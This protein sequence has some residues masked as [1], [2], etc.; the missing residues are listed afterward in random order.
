[1]KQSVKHVFF[2]AMAGI[3]LLAACAPAPAPTQDPAEVQ[4]QIQESVA[5]TVA[6]QNAEAEQNQAVV[7]EPTN[8]PLPTQT[9][10]VPASP[11]PVEPTATPFTVVPPTV[12]PVSSGSGGGGAVTPLEYD[13]NV[14]NRQ[15]LDNTHFK[16]NKE[17]DIRW[18]IINTGTKSWPAGLD[19]K[20]YSGP[21]M[22]TTTVAEL[23]AMAPGDTFE[24]I[25]DARAPQKRGFQVMT[26]I[27]EGKLCYPYV[28][29]IVGE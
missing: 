10:A 29:I 16:P 2:L 27:V 12:T 7:A 28:A 13:C 3:L 5:L 9:E 22:S 15:P 25:L 20:Y 17:F 26:W 19:V 14:G 21:L 8:T 18:T 11:T 1:M 6:A 24:V 4:R 23:P